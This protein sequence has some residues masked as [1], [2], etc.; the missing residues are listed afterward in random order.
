MNIKKKY[1]LIEINIIVVHAKFAV[2]W[3]LYI[4]WS[5]HPHMRS[6]HN[7]NNGI[8]MYTKVSRHITSR[9]LGVF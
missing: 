9:I 5:Q 7:E 1:F 3:Q 2:E 4:D 8:H 6:Q